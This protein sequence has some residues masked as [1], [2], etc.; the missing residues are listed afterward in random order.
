MVLVPMKLRR[1]IPLLLACALGL[2][3]PLPVCAGVLSLNF[4]RG[5]DGSG[6]LAELDVAGVVAVANWNNAPQANANSNTGFILLDDAGTNSGTTADWQSGGASWSVATDGTGEAGDKIMMT[7][8]LDQGGNG[9]G[10]IHTITIY[11]IPF[12]QY[13]VYLYHSSSGGPNRTAR[14]QA[15]TIGP[16]SEH[17]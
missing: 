7:G 11:D 6:A 3:S 5:S 1:D 12:A 2:I 16:G 17:R 4:V 14:Y 15:N 10:Q 13:D 9:V 8:Y